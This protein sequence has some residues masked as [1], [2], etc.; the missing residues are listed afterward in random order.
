MQQS[1]LQNLKD[2]FNETH[3][4]RYGFNAPNEPVEIQNLGV[5]AIGTVEKYTLKRK[6]VKEKKNPKEA[7][8]EARQVCIDGERYVECPVYDRSLL[9]SGCIVEGPAV[10]Q[11]PASTL[12][13]EAGNLA[14][15]H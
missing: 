15:M 4:V 8:K 2:K 13:L 9:S 10:I 11:E 6:Q 7:Y 1:Y 12:I 14:S 5:A 3:L